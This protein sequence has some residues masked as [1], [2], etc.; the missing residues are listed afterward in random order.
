MNNTMINRKST[1]TLVD[2]NLNQ[3][4]EE[5]LQDYPQTITSHNPVC[6]EIMSIMNKPQDEPASFSLQEC[7][8]VDTTLSLSVP[9]KANVK[10]KT[11][12]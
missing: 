1:L 10:T 9:R 3:I 6:R 12:D 2:Y 4:A 5:E 11:K 7:S 8:A